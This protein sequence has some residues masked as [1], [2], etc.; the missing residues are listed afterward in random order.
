M[1]WNIDAAHSAIEFGVKHLGISTT[2]GRFQ[3][4][5]GIV[6]TA[7]DGALRA[8]EVAIDAA[9]INTNVADRD[10]HLKSA[11]FFNVQRFPG[12]T[13]RSTAVTP[14]P[15]GTYR[16]EGDLTM[17]GVTRPVSFTAEV[18][19]PVTDPWGNRRI[20]GRATGKLNRKEWGL[21]WNQLLE[22][23]GLVVGEEVRFNLDIE[24]VAEAAAAEA[25]SAE[26][27]AA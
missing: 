12:I 7:P 2:K 16:I 25:A 6:R 14:N 20:A 1:Q 19:Q 18:E 15:D 8:L 5:Q 17:R 27:V 24:V 26:A 10:A 11:D 4:F 13:Y 9:S 21:T 23:G 3:A 22:T